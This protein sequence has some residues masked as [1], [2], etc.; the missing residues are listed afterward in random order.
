MHSFSLNQNII[1]EV[2]NTSLIAGEAIL[3]IYRTNFD[4]EIKKDFSPLTQAD[5]ASHEIILSSLKKLTPNIPILSE[6]SSEIPYEQRSGWIDYWLVDPLDGTKEFINKNG[7]FTTNIALISEN[8]PIFGV[9]Y[10]PAIKEIYWG[11]HLSG[12]FMQISGKKPKKISVKSKAS[13][14]TNVV[15]S[16]SHKSDT[17]EHFLNKIG[18][19]KEHQIGSSLKFCLLASG[20]ADIYPR[21]GPTSE[22]DIAAGDAILSYAGGG[23]VDSEKN[24]ILYNIKE[25]LLNGSFFAFTN[26]ETMDKLYLDFFKSVI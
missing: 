20:K 21:F 16:R 8:R 18:D 14:I 3:D 23:I 22:W 12:S 11:S 13:N 17:E 6:E 2:I 24:N 5:L 25:D 15:S 10:A 19:H 26:R 7:E 1:D 4:I 9:I